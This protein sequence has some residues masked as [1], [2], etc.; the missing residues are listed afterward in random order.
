VV[1][2]VCQ[3]LKSIHEEY[4]PRCL[5]WKKGGLRHVSEPMVKFFV[6]VARSV[7]VLKLQ[8]RSPPSLALNLL[9]LAATV[10]GLA[11]KLKELALD[12]SFNFKASGELFSSLGMHSQITKLSLLLLGETELKCVASL[13]GM[14][15]L[16]VRQLTFV[17][18]GTDCLDPCKCAGKL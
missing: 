18:S 7:E 11:P 3:K 8:F 16:E 17:G 4:P 10:N 6:H 5:D 13:K 9:V 12:I 1:P 15:A 14:R 2:L